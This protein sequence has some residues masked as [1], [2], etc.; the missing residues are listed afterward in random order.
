MSLIIENKEAL[1]SLA[2][3]VIK[4]N[5][6]VNDTMA[7]KGRLAEIVDNIIPQKTRFASGVV[8][9]A[10]EITTDNMPEILYNLGTDEN[11]NVIIPDLILIYQPEG[12]LENT[13]DKD[14][15]LFTLIHPL[16][17][18]G[19]TNKGV[20]MSENKLTS[21][22]YVAGTIGNANSSTVVRT[23]DT[24]FFLAPRV[25]YPWQAAKPIV[26]LQIKF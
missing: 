2:N 1:D 17:V 25:S 6:S 26:W 3:S 8:I 9:P 11:G 21:G 13:G 20:Y 14:A 22:Y 18:R 12:I 7:T 19:E 10:M 23:T 5:M 24:S 16:L 15:S 4:A